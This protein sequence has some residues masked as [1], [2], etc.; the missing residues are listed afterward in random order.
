MSTIQALAAYAEA[1]AN[2]E[3]QEA[4]AN[5]AKEILRAKEKELVETMLKENVRSL[6]DD[7]GRLFSM[8]PRCFMSFTLGNKDEVL[9]FLEG[10]GYE[11][12][13]LVREEIHSTR[14]RELIREIYKKE[15]KAMLPE[16]L[17]FDDTA[18]ITV[19]GWKGEKEV[20]N[21]SSAA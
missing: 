16:C 1:R 9:A 10:R 19:R 15:G 8:T 2:K 21:E 7:L 20:A 12:N 6:K 4:L 14:A 5:K 13:D 17:K 18:G 11:R 3:T